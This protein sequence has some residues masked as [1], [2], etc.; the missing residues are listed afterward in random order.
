MSFTQVFNGAELIHHRGV[1]TRSIVED[2]NFSAVHQDQPNAGTDA[3]LTNGELFMTESTR[4]KAHLAIAKDTKQVCMLPYAEKA[5]LIFLCQTSN[6]NEHRAINHRFQ[7]H[8]GK[9]VTGIGATACA[10]HGCYC[11]GSVVDFQKGER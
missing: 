9:D 7:T 8:K 3:A 5:Y 4:Y 2:G 1:Y 6:C 10:R 11:P